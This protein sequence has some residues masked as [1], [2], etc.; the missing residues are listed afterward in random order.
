MKL[1]PYYMHPVIARML[2]INLEQ[3]LSSLL[4]PLPTSHI[5]I[6][7]VYLQLKCYLV[8]EKYL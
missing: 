6:P 1:Y 8:L 2:S 7:C 5:D 3:R 4:L